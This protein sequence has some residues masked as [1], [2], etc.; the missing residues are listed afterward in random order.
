MMRSVYEQRTDDARE[1]Q[2]HLCA[3]T[4]R[5]SGRKF[6]AVA[7]LLWPNKTAAYLASIAGY[8][9]RTAER[10]L[11]GEYEPPGIVIAAVIVE[12]TRRT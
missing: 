2:R 4:T 10:W 8:D 1:I 9:Q 6:G 5:V 11:S 12:I 7:K 3:G